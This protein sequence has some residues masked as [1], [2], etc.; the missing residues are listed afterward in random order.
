MCVSAYLQMIDKLVPNLSQT[1]DILQRAKM[2]IFF[3][4]RTLG[5]WC[6]KRYVASALHFN[7]EM[8]VLSCMDRSMT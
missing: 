4:E 1:S 7:H 8:H 3:F 5:K 2:P 6:N